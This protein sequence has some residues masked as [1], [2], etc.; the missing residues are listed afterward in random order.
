ML[1]EKVVD[2]ILWSIFCST[3]SRMLA[4][5]ARVEDMGAKV[6]RKPMVRRQR[7]MTSFLSTIQLRFSEVETAA[8]TRTFPNCLERKRT[9]VLAVLLG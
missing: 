6:R 8:R 5:I 2:A 3:L 9:L 1:D 7:A 4:S